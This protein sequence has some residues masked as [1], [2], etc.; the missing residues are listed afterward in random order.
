MVCVFS[1]CMWCGCDVGL[2]GGVVCAYVYVVCVMW[3]SDVGV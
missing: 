2:V 1:V 3:V